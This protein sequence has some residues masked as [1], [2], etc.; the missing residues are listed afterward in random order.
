MNGLTT[1]RS[2]GAARRLAVLCVLCVSVPAAFGQ[3]IGLALGSATGQPGGSV[4][5]PLSLTTSGA[6]V[7][8]ISWTFAY[9][10]AD[11]SKVSVAAGPAASAAAKSIS[12]QETSAGRSTC[13]AYG[14]NRTLIANGVLAN[15]T[16]TLAANTSATTTSIQNLNPGGASANGDPVIGTGSAGA[17]TITRPVSLSAVACSPATLVAPASSQCTVS[18]TAAAPPSGIAVSLG[19]SASGAT[20]SMPTSLTVPSGSTNSRFTL[21]ASAATRVTSVQVSATAAGITKTASVAISPATTTPPPAVSVTVSPA[22]VTLTA[23]GTQQFTAAVS[24]TTNTQV[25]WSLSS[26][27]GTISSAGLYRA[28]TSVTARQTVT[29]RATSVANTTKV[30]T[31]AVVI[32]PVTAPPTTTLYSVFTAAVTPSTLA[33]ADSK[34]VELGMKFSSTVDGFVTGVRFYKGSTQN[35]GQHVANLWTTSG[36][37]LATAIFTNETSSGWQQVNFATPVAVKANA[38]YVVSYF[39][40]YGRYAA[41]TNYFKSAIGVSPFWIPSGAG[42][43]RYGSSSG[44]PTQS[45]ND[46]NYWVDVIFKR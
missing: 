36:Q 19:Y 14:L 5:V 23:G 41:N 42:V 43:Y 12:C 18:L 13:V 31:A 27:V 22:S 8:S 1:L 10:A 15:A 25:T 28:P 46:S 39:A 6:Q 33:D 32:N 9:A 45:Y 40:P 3:S 29:V 4:S 17:I 16:F 2:S 35:R 24:G 38:I 11:I 21:Q 37:R 7:S 30:S 34:A 26:A 20:I 44:F